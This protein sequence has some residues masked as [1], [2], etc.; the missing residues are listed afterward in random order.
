[1]MLSAGTAAA[2]GCVSR[3]PP[4]AEP[5][6]AITSAPP[7]EPP[8]ILPPLTE[9]EK[10]LLPG[11]RRH[12]AEL[13]HTIGERNASKMWELAGAADY[14]ATELEKAGYE[15]DRQGYEVGEI[16]AQNLTVELQGAEQGREIVVVG[17]HYDSAE[18]TPGADDNA[19]GVAAVLELARLFR[20]ASPKRTLRFALFSTEEPPYFQTENM[21]SLRWAKRAAAA[22][23]TV[24]AMLSLESIGFFC[25]QP[26][27]QKTPEGVA[28][29]VPDRGDFIAVVGNEANAKLVDRV[30]HAIIENGSIPAHGAAWRQDLPG[31]AWSDQWSFWRVGY[32]AVMVTDTAPFRNPNYHRASDTF[33]TLD[34]ERMT[35]VVAGLQGVIRE[36]ALIASEQA[37]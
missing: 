2:F 10:Q 32:P 7:E 26:R 30:L 9:V 23:E 1:M 37:R 24:V 19:S 29:D 12:V 21:G 6:S 16:A 15:V 8:R 5:A 14:L 34:F 3:A 17:A 4:I 35:R 31:V 28:A 20:G 36:L 33:E 18:G 22:G 11:L 27:C 13:S 25:D